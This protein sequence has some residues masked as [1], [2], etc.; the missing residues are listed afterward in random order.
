[1]VHVT[2]RAL[3][4][5]AWEI[6]PTHLETASFLIGVCLVN[7]IVGVPLLWCAAGAVLLMSAGAFLTAAQELWEVSHSAAAKN[8]QVTAPEDGAG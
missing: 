7:L 3:C 6:R 8:P 4:R 1:V 5:R 2:G